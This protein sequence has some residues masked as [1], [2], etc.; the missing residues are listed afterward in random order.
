MAIFIHASLWKGYLGVRQTACAHIVG[1][2]TVSSNLYPKF[3]TAGVCDKGLK[4]W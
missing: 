1:R 2:S 4:S 3:N